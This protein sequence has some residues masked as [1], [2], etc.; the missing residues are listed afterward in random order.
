MIPPV[1]HG[2]CTSPGER[3][4]FRRLRDDPATSD[5]IVLHS[6][7]VAEHRKQIAGE[8]DFVVIV[9]AKGVLCLEVKACRS[10]RRDGGLW[11][12]GTEA[13]ADARGPF[14]QASA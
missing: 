13:K 9:P 11:Y 12:Y 5:W 14:K 6:L 4:I 3:E 8:I 1:V 7:D 2:G 10:L